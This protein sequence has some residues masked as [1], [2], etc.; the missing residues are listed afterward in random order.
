MLFVIDVVVSPPLNYSRTP[1]PSHLYPDNALLI[2]RGRRARPPTHS[3]S[4]HILPSFLHQILL[5]YSSLITGLLS[6]LIGQGAGQGG[7]EVGGQREWGGV[8]LE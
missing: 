4:F 3:T 6:G 1:S 5:Y 2:Q 8:K 7:E